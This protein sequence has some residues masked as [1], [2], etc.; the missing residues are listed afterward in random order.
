MCHGNV[1]AAQRAAVVRL[2]GGNAHTMARR[3]LQRD[4]QAVAFARDRQAARRGLVAEQARLIGVAA[5]RQAPCAVHG[6]PLLA[7]GIAKNE[8]CLGRG[9]RHADGVGADREGDRDGAACAIDRKASG[10][11][12]ALIARD[13]I[14]IASG[15]KA[16]GAV[17]L[18][19]LLHVLRIVDMDGSAGHVD[20]EGHDELGIRILPGK[21]GIAAVLILRVVHECAAELQHGVERLQL[22]FREGSCV[23]GA[24]ADG[25][26]AR[27]VIAVRNGAAVVVADERARIII[28]ARCGQCDR[29]GIVAG[30]H[31][32]VRIRL[33]ENAADAVAGG[34][35]DVIALA[36]RSIVGSAND[37]GR[38][39][40]R[41]IA[42]RAEVRAAQDGRTR[43]GLAVQTADDTADIP[44]RTGD[45]GIVRA[46]LDRG[47]VRLTGDAADIAA[48]G[49]AAADRQAAYGRAGIQAAEQTGIVRR[50]R[51]E[52]IIDRVIRTVKAARKAAGIAADRREGHIAHVQIGCECHILSGKGI[53]GGDLCG[54]IGQLLAV[55]DEIGIRLRAGAAR[56]AVC[57]RSIPFDAGDHGDLDCRVSLAERER[58]ACRLI[59]RSLHLIG[60]VRREEQIGAVLLGLHNIVAVLHGNGRRRA[61]GK[62]RD[63]ERH[64]MARKLRH[65]HRDLNGRIRHGKAA[66]G[67]R[68]AEGLGRI[69]VLARRNAGLAVRHGIGSIR[70]V[71]QRKG[72]ACRRARERDAIVRFAA[73]VLQI[74]RVIVLIAAV[75]L[76]I[77]DG[78][79][80]IR[81][82]L[83]RVGLEG[84]HRTGIRS[85]AGL[86]QVRSVL[87][88]RHV[89][90][91]GLAGDLIGEAERTAA[92]EGQLEG[93]SRPPHALVAG[94]QASLVVALRKGIGGVV[95]H[96]RRNVRKKLIE[97]CRCC[98]RDAAQHHAQHKDRRDHSFHDPIFLS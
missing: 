31:G 11:I 83:H 75:V 27:E 37:T 46:G 8:L 92:P 55:R 64:L 44:A 89:V 71:R 1:R 17:L 84:R 45:R 26:H 10:H 30:R 78:H 50:L 34:G 68:I 39:I 56:K 66:G 52:Q 53:A 6:A 61:R 79:D 38:E 59:A 70:A 33:A 94:Y 47:A 28:V 24:S 14:G 54:E 97:T 18:R 7:I 25:L 74:E 58:A 5:L 95:F 91:V 9:Q 98:D 51:D 32:R 73:E 67:L 65:G 76:G 36:Q 48:A 16:I 15:D 88:D 43:S 69:A 20:G 60:I 19:G 3:L 35:A 2:H 21:D 86:R 22:L 82:D 40:V 42:D 90:I 93:G 13:K 49:D 72:R 41:T 85:L 80:V 77:P 96:G 63:R 4:M 29:T 87:R 12:V 81:R 23:A 57:H 62:A